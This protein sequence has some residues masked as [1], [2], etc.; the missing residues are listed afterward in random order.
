MTPPSFVAIGHLTVDDLVVHDGAVRMGEP[1]GAALYAALGARLLGVPAAMLSRLGTG[2]PAQRLQS[3]GLDTSLLETCD[4]PAIHEWVLYEADGTRQFVLQSDSGTMADMTPRPAWTVPPDDAAVHL[5]PMHVP[6]QRAW[7]SALTA[8]RR[9]LTLDPHVESCSGDPAVVLG[10]LP[11]IT[12]FLPSELEATCL[13]GPGPVEAVQ[14]FLSAGAPIA[15]V[16]LG[17][18]GS[19]VGSAEAIWH[20]PAVPVGV[21]DVTGAGDTYC[22]AFATALGTGCDVV[23]AARWATAAASL[24]VEWRGIGFAGV[25]D[26]QELVAERMSAVTPER[27]AGVL[28]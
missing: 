26:A 10:L 23:T 16:K 25:D 9:V 1:G 7:C 17:R 6:F 20:V 27:V 19:V 28:A 11:E 18:E 21:R 14:S 4:S 15:V 12:A 22:G 8:T 24:A 5:A 2:F 3:T 13:A